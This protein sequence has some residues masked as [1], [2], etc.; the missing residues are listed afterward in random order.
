M[1]PHFHG[2]LQLIA[3]QYIN[4][5]ESIVKPMFFSYNPILVPV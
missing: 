2:A 1:Y 4:L 5:V 3:Q